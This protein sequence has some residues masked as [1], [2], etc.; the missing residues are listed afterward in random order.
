MADRQTERARAEA[1]T[2]GATLE[3]EP[4]SV[5]FGRPDKD[6]VAAVDVPK[7]SVAP[8]T[9]VALSGPSGS[10]KTT[11]LH[12]LAGVLKPTTGRVYWDGI[13]IT[14]LGEGRRDRWRRKHVGLIFQEFHLIEQLSP[15]ANVLLPA[16]FAAFRSSAALRRRAA[17]LLE[18]LGVP[19]A[20][21]AVS[22]LSRGERQRVAIARAL[23]FDPPILL[24]DEPTA[25]LDAAA[26]EQVSVEL[27]KA[28]AAGRTTIVASH[29]R[30]IVDRCERVIRL[31][32]GKIVSDGGRAGGKPFLAEVRS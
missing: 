10:G 23:L 12:V 30:L 11:L 13:E 5:L 27:A 2:S 16:S 6:A 32:H 25:S 14:G 9:F 3:A 8:G 21:A 4:I 7:L 18:E 29:D 19:T 28:A 24:A 17:Q 26:G 31:E 15:V 20:R 1:E 22:D